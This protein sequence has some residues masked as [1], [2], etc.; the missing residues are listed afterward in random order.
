MQLIQERRRDGHVVA[1]SLVVVLA[2]AVWRGAAGAPVVAALLGVVWLVIVAGWIFW[3][4]RPPSELHVS[5]R[6]ITWGSPDRIAT[7]FTRSDGARLEFRRNHVNQT[8][9][10]LRLAGEP[11]AGA[12]S[13]LGFDMKEVARAAVE[14]GWHFDEASAAEETVSVGR[15]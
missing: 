6:E 5:S 8:G 11:E 13:M 10:Y 2:L 14:R 12:I 1:G 7:R 9:W 3:M 4:R 15:G